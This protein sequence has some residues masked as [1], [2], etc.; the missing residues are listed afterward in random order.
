MLLDRVECKPVWPTLCGSQSGLFQ[1]HTAVFKKSPANLT[2]PRLLVAHGRKK[3]CI[4]A[5]G[6]EKAL[7][8]AANQIKNDL[9]AL[10]KAREEKTMTAE[11]ANHALRAIN[12]RIRDWDA[13][14]REAIKRL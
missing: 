10:R 2:P 13:S 4:L 12:K 6:M 8:K 5:L 14:C 7:K 9:A 3:P 11:N 1:L